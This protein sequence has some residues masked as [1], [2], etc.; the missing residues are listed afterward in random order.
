MINFSKNQQITLNTLFQSAWSLMLNFYSSRR[1][2]LHGTTISTRP[3]EIEGSDSILGL[4]I[5]TIPIRTTIDYQKNTKEWL[6]E[7]QD[8]FKAKMPHLNVPLQRIIEVSELNADQSL[9]DTL[10]VF[11]NYPFDELVKKAFSDIEI[12]DLQ[13]VEKTNFPITIVIVPGEKYLL[14]A[15]Y[16][17]NRFDSQ[18]IK[19]LLN[20]LII[21]LKQLVKNAENRLSDVYL[22]DSEEQE[23]YLTRYLNNSVVANNQLVNKLFAQQ[24]TQSNPVYILNQNLKPLPEEHTGKLYIGIH[25]PNF[26]KAS[27]LKNPYSTEYNKLLDT[28]FNAKWLNDN[29]LSIVSKESRIYY[30]GNKLIQLSRIEAAIMAESGVE[31]CAVCAYDKNNDSNIL[32]AYIVANKE[33]EIPSFKQ[34]L[35]EKLS[36]NELP[37]DFVNLSSIPYDSEG[38]IDYQKLATIEIIDEI[39]VSDWQKKWSKL[40][41]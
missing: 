30:A 31:N 6:I 21:T 23:K 28:S 33:I 2:V 9:F 41:V 1:D 10:L 26:D 4:F 40:P 36:E 8:L 18:D 24:I 32:I 38:K 29:T 19:Q 15:L 13:Y 35:L 39:V 17:E 25:E 22:M 5:N 3:V 27:D 12:K 7:Q 14:R 11:E 34:R 37:A 20:W 16:D